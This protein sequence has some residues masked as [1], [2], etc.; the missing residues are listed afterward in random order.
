MIF[1]EALIA[2][3]LVLLGTLCCATTAAMLAAGTS[4]K[5]KVCLDVIDLIGR[6][7]GGTV[8]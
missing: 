2:S 8:K 7:T 3:A 1:F 4:A 5:Y 6:A